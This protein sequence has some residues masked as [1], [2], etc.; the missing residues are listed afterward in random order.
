M[1]DIST[2]FK[3]YL[4]MLKTPGGVDTVEFEAKFGTIA[5]KPNTQFEY[6]NVIKYLK[7]SGFKHSKDEY[8]LRIFPTEIDIGVRIEIRGMDN[9]QEYCLSNDINKVDDKYSTVLKK[10]RIIGGV[11][12]RPELNFRLT[13]SNEVKLEEKS[14]IKVKKELATY[15]KKFRMMNRYTYTHPEFPVL[16]DLSVVESSER[17][18][19]TFTDGMLNVK[20]TYEIEIEFKNDTVKKMNYNN[21]GILST[22]NKVAKC[23]LAGYQESWFP[24]GVTEQSNIINSYLGLI[25]K[26]EKEINLSHDFIGPSSFTLEL[27]NI[28]GTSSQEP[29][30]TKNYTVTDKAD[31]ARKMLFINEKGRM[32]LITTG[33]K[34]QYTGSST[35]S[36]SLYN[37]LI[38][39]EHIL[40]DKN[41]KFINYYAAFDLY[42][43]HGEDIRALKFKQEGDV[44]EERCRYTELVKVIAELNRGQIK[45]S[46]GGLVVRP[47]IFYQSGTKET[48][49]IFNAC[50][51]ILQSMKNG[52]FMY[53]TDGLIFTPADKGVG[54]GGDVETPPNKTVTW[55]GSFKWKP[56]E[57]NTIDFAVKVLQMKDGSDIRYEYQNG[58]DVAGD[59]R[60]FGYKTLILS[61]GKSG[62]F[63]PKNPPDDN[64]GFSNIKLQK[65]INGELVMMAENNDIITDGAV[66]EFKYVKDNKERWRW[67]PLRV[68]YDKPYANSYIVAESNWRSIHYP[69]TA[70]YLS[71]GVNDKL[72]NKY[73]IE[74]TDKEGVSSGL[75]DFH[76]RYIKQSLI[77]LVSEKGSTIIDLAVGVGSDIYKWSKNGKIKFAF[78]VDLFL[79]NIEILEKRYKQYKKPDA[80]FVQGNSTLNFRNE[81]AFDSKEDKEKAA[82]VFGQS[83]KQTAVKLN[84]LFKNYYGIG[85]DGFDICSIQFAIH[86]MFENEKTL[87]GFLENVNQNT[88]MGGYF[89]G[90]SFDGKNVFDKLKDKNKG[91]TFSINDEKSG[92]PI[93]TITKG[94]DEKTFRPNLSSLGYSI[95]VLQNTIGTVQKE[96]LVNYEYLT[97]ELDKYGFIPVSTTDLTTLRKNLDIG[98]NV[99]RKSIGTFEELYSNLESESS[100]LTKANKSDI[101]NAL[102]MTK[103]EKEVSFMNKY[104]IYKKVGHGINIKEVEKKVVEKK[105]VEKKVVEKKVVEKKEPLREI[106]ATEEYIEEEKQ[107]HKEIDDL[108]QRSSLED[109]M[110]VIDTYE[111]NAFTAN[112]KKEVIDFIHHNFWSIEKMN[113]FIEK[114]NTVTRAPIIPPEKREVAEEI[115]TSD[116]PIVT[117]AAMKGVAKRAAKGSPKSKQP[118]PPELS[119]A[120]TQPP[121][122]EKPK[123]NTRK[124]KVKE[125]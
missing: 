17:E 76:N 123:K 15:R 117:K 62:Q 42:F 95:E 24:I 11:V 102:N 115:S 38:D 110:S 118:I 104:F 80:I 30:I 119:G 125:L 70:E 6:E 120:D 84:P 8:L 73:Y 89:I 26:K 19:L 23:I 49:T 9:I 43:N 99:F 25:K 55:V 5:S 101:R 71:T 109:I 14:V 77:E 78:G 92:N 56:V 85:K 18:S 79:S 50:N 20:K 4:E 46:E 57:Y 87:S 91:E 112:N 59:S 33:M 41:G 121:V 90:T 22:F 124:A 122:P 53:I 107:L 116:K 13:L 31:G 35:M 36:A 114:W 106:L 97:E 66:V 1:S 34:V 48:E 75:R 7:S 113:G 63:K 111:Y 94:Y 98:S 81:S 45:P 16:I 58:S 28:T 86:Y 54:V 88:K 12:E 29:N 10:S 39:G 65:N 69:I 72:A 32:Y 64:A 96:Y 3:D 68:R 52:N 21:T 2:I 37:T 51:Q 108:L 40:N 61:A 44:G 82:A 103:S 74:E 100:G 47:K 60:N 93:L 27:K 83:N 67:E 105:V